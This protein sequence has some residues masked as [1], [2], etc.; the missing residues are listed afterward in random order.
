MSRQIKDIKDKNTGQLVY[1]RTHISAIVV[2]ASTYL[3]TFIDT[4]NTRLEEQINNIWNWDKLTGL[5]T[6][7]IDNRT[8]SAID[9]MTW[10][11]W[12]ES[13]YNSSPYQ[14]Y[15]GSEIKQEILAGYMDPSG[16]WVE[17]IYKYVYDGNIRVS[18]TDIIEDNKSYVGK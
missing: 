16:K 2:D 9:G 14:D 18:N 1:P 5:I 13:R 8:Y 10:R 3:D 4:N 17:S 7:T 6:F 11:E 15:W 12:A